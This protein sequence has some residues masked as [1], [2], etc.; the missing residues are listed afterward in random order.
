MSLLT[1]IDRAVAGDCP[2]GAA[3][4]PGSAYC[5][6]LCE[7]THRAANTADSSARWHPGLAGF[8]EGTPPAAD[9][10]W[11]D[12]EI[13]HAYTRA[14][15]LADGALVDAGPVAREAGFRI[16]LALTQAAWADCVAWTDADSE[17]KGT[18]QDEKGRL[19]DVLT[20]AMLAARRA[21]DRQ[22]VPFELVRVP[23]AGRGVRPRLT[24]LAMVIGP[25]DEGEPVITIMLPEED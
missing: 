22:R 18:V 20:M 19:W 2:C 25:G 3:P 1:R 13:I 10:F 9:D 5:G 12:A 11:V 23:V 15:A 14:Q 24:T 6:Q 4:R 16:P 21:G 17:R 8:E 7:P